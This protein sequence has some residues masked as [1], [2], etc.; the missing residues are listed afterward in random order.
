[1]EA[2]GATTLMRLHELDDSLT[3]SVLE[4]GEARSLLFARPA[5]PQPGARIALALRIDALGVRA[6]LDLPA[7]SARAVRARLSDPTAALEVTAA[8][9][10]LPEQFTIGVDGDPSDTQ[11]L[12]CTTHGLRQ[13]LDRGESSGRALRIEWRLPRDVAARHA[14]ILE[15]ELEDAVVVLGELLMLLADEVEGGAATLRPQ[16][17]PRRRGRRR[18]ASA[19][20]RSGGGRFQTDL[21]D[22]RDREERRARAP[23]RERKRDAEMDA[24]PAPRRGVDAPAPL[25]GIA[26]PRTVPRAGLRRRPTAAAVDPIKRGAHVR[27]LTGP[28][29]GKVGVVQDLDGKGGARVLLGLLAVH[30]GVKDLVASPEGRQRPLLSTSHR[31]LPPVRS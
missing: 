29:S 17:R 13:L 4:V 9:E 2:W 18:A 7:A 19:G 15:E 27:V 5:T 11:A 21:E 6:S 25:Q 16:R 31:K 30:L 14:A 3:A 8:L 24:E 22:D 23:R 1:M 10:A 28:F 20:A 26:G 12:G